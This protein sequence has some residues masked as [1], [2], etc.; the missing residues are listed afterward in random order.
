MSVNNSDVSRP[1]IDMVL[2]IY[3]VYPE[4]IGYEHDIH[5]IGA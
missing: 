5:I 1:L 4:L 3:N 2:T